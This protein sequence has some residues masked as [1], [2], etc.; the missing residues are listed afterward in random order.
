MIGINQFLY[1][2]FTTEHASAVHQN[3]NVHQLLYITVPSPVHQLLYTPVMKT[4]HQLVYTTVMTTVHQLLYIHHSMTPVHNYR[5]NCTLA[6][7]CTP[8]S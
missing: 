8:Q 5:G 6:H 7:V 1:S 4:V 3:Y 2:T